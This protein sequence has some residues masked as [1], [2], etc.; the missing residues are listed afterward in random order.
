MHRL[1]LGLIPFLCLALIACSGPDDTDPV[2][3]EVLEWKSITGT[4]SY[5]E[6]IMLTPAA[7]VTVSLEDVSRADAPAIMVAQ[8]IIEAPGQVPV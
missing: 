6:R 7:I 1:Q 4:V 2:M 5:R 3:P 8:H